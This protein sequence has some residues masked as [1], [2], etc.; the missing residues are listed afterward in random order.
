MSTKRQKQLK[1]D[2]FSVQKNNRKTYSGI[3]NAQK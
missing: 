2:F 1:N 3:R